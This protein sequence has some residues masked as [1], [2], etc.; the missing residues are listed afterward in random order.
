M[1]K[2]QEEKEIPVTVKLKKSVHKKVVDKQ[3]DKFDKE[4]TI[5][6]ICSLAIEKGIDK[7]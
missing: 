4:K 1:K 7:V 5:P 6:E 2:P 3:I